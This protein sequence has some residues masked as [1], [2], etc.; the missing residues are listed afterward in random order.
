M[1]QE[2][3]RVEALRDKQLE[4]YEKTQKKD[5]SLKEFNLKK[6]IKLIKDEL[7]KL[8]IEPYFKEDLDLSEKFKKFE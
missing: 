5:K 7:E 4:E 6:D 3:G 2:L 8:K 1:H